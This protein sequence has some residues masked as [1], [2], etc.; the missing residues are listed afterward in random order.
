[1]P[2]N[3]EQPS[4][5]FLTGYALKLFTNVPIIWEL[6]LKNLVN[7]YLATKNSSEMPRGSH[8]ILHFSVFITKFADRFFTDGQHKQTIL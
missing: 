2:D 5:P 8:Y 4:R 7:I 6:M 3:K 1:M